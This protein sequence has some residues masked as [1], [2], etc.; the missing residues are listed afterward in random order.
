MNIRR[1][2]PKPVER[3]LIQARIEAEIYEL[4]RI[5]LRQDNVQIADFIEAAAKAYLEERAKKRKD[6]K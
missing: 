1:H 5:Q 2:L 6:E 3:K 4:L